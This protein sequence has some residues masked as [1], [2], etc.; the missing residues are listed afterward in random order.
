MI[1]KVKHET[2]ATDDCIPGSFPPPWFSK[3][4]ST[5]RDDLSRERGRED[6]RGSKWSGDNPPGDEGKRN[7]NPGAKANLE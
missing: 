1:F 3:I 6:R 4:T 5:G 7:T 2:M